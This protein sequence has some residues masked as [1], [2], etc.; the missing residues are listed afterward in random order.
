MAITSNYEESKMRGL[1]LLTKSRI[2]IP[3]Y[4]VFTLFFLS[5]FSVAGQNRYVAEWLDVV[6]DA[7]Q[8]PNWSLRADVGG[9]FVT[10]PNGQYELDTSFTYLAAKVRDS[11]PWSQFDTVVITNAQDVINFYNRIPFDVDAIAIKNGDTIPANINRFGIWY[12]TLRYNNGSRPGP[13]TEVR[14][15]V[16]GLQNCA[17]TE[18]LTIAG[19][20]VLIRNASGLSFVDQVW[21]DANGDFSVFLDGGVYL[22]S[23]NPS[24]VNW[25]NCNQTRQI[26]IDT[27]YYPGLEPI[28][29][30]EA[31]DLG[32]FVVAQSDSSCADLKVEVSTYALRPCFSNTYKVAYSNAGS[33]AASDV[34][35]N[36][37]LDSE[38]M[39]D[40]ASAEF[41][42]IENGAMQFLIGD[43][44]IGE[45]GLI[46]LHV[47]LACN[48]E[49]VGNTYCVEAEILGQ[50]LC[51]D[52]FGGATLIVTGECSGDSVLFRIQNIG[53]E[54]TLG[55]VQYIVVEDVTSFA[56]EHDPIGPGE[57]FDLGFPA[58]GATYRIEVKQE[59]GNPRG[60]FTSKTIE[61]CNVQSHS[62]SQGFFTMF[63][64]PDEAAFVA[65]DCRESTA[66]FDPNDKM[67]FPKGIEP[68]NL[69]YPGTEIEYQIRFQNTGTDTAFKVEIVDGL[70]PGIDPLSVQFGTSSHPYQVEVNG[71]MLRFVFEDIN[72]P[73]SSTDME[74]SQG[75]VTFKVR[76]SSDLQVGDTLNNMALIYFD[77]NEAIETNVTQHILVKRNFSTSETS[78]NSGQREIPVFPNPFPG[79][80]LYFDYEFEG[81]A[82]V[83]FM[84]CWEDL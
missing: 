27:Q 77:F 36:L 72:L 60:A 71:P 49:N 21:T 26:N 48:L 52:N 20:P 28:M 59:T 47:H 68:G 83:G 58:N 76:Q 6:E 32:T 19:I 37:T 63:P 3:R 43:L 75:F 8:I 56:F 74:A 18:E 81:L 69:I 24:T 10:K 67:G 2:M 42:I 23:T 12:D 51:H 31:K 38:M 14:G 70:A 41:Q 30:P 65:I 13:K 1:P 84:I 29:I 45:G 7:S 50:N 33:D 57:F 66:S 73:D 17:E 40:S 80:A 55:P 11:L 46:D 22:F 53:D 34:K 5:S 39:I 15:S 61:G 4:I 54:R 62:S 78:E 79:G 82:S 35:I 16:K 64:D 44:N 9:F 25:T